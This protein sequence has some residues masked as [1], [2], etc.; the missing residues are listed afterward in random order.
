VFRYLHRTLWQNHTSD[1][2]LVLNT[3]ILFRALDERH[4]ENELLALAL[5]SVKNSLQVGVPA[6]LEAVVPA[7]VERVSGLELKVGLTLV[8]PEARGRD[9][10]NVVNKVCVNRANGQREAHFLECGRGRVEV[11]SLLVGD[12]AEVVLQ[13]GRAVGEPV[14]LFS[15]DV[16]T[17][18][19]DLNISLKKGAMC[20]RLGEL[21]A[22]ADL[23]LSACGK[24]A[25]GA[26]C[27]CSALLLGVFLAVC[28]QV[29]GEHGGIRD[30]GGWELE[31]GLL[32][33][34]CVRARYVGG[35]LVQD[36]LL[37][38]LQDLRGNRLESGEEEVG[39]REGDLLVGGQWCRKGDFVVFGRALVC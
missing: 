14:A 37:V 23:L 12:T 39:D 35:E 20:E 13:L 38:V 27:E 28:V 9:I 3:L 22:H 33:E 19:A 4:F 17:P 18:V 36:I 32:L 11:V 2:A 6:S 10:S 15:R 16:T 25:V 30:I 1:N 29:G 5:D 8:G 26:V 7:T 21:V 24:L 34:G 31:L